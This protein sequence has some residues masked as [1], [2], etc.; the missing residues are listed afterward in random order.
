MSLRTRKVGLVIVL[1]ASDNFLTKINFYLDKNVRVVKTNS[2]ARFVKRK[3]CIE[4]VLARLASKDGLS[5]RQIVISNDLR[6]G[7][8][9]RGYNDIPD[10]VNGVIYKITKFA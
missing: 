8:V 10:S 7:L 6:N 1:F 5:F 3:D 9:A 4:E 2:I